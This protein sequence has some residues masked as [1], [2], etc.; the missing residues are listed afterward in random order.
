MRLSFA[1]WRGVGAPAPPRA[2][3]AQILL[4]G[5]GGL[6]A[7]GVV[8]GLASLTQLPWILGSFGATCVLVFGFPEAPFSQPRAVIGGH[9]VASTIGVAA[10]TLCGPSWWC[11]A[12]AGSAAIMAMMALRIVHPPAG[13]NPIIAVVGV[14]HWDFIL[15]PT[16]LGAVAIV[17]CALI[18]LNAVRPTA[19]PQ[20]W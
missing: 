12:I 4:A 15:L 20:R 10:V 9:L 14:A 17:L 1:K 3:L 8:A 5:L 6:L 13:S 19:Y 11:L 18:Y 7:L 2:P 16:L